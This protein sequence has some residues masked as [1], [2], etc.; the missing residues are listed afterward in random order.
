MA[1]IVDRTF[2]LLFMENLH[3]DFLRPRDTHDRNV[4]RRRRQET[5]A[6]RLLWF[7]APEDLIL[8]KLGTPQPL[9]D[10]RRTP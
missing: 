2:S 1:D 9:T 10:L 3:V 5:F 6:G 4:L 7:P 8:M